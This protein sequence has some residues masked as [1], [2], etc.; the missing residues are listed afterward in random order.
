[1]VVCLVFFPVSPVCLIFFL[2]WRGDSSLVF[3]SFCEKWLLF[4]G[5]RFGKGNHFQ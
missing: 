1:L 3:V 5:L 2:F 4:P